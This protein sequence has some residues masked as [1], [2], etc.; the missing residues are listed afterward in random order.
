MQRAVFWTCNLRFII[1]TKYPVRLWNHIISNT[2][3]ELN[4]E[5]W[6]WSNISKCGIWFNYRSVKG[7]RT[8]SYL[9]LLVPAPTRPIANMALWATS[10]SLSCENLLSVSKMLSFGL[11]T[12]IRPSA[13]GTDLLITGSQYR[14]CKDT[15]PCK[16]WMTYY[17]R[18][19]FQLQSHIFIQVLTPGLIQKMIQF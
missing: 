16:I 2:T 17:S 5:L 4:G 1:K 12:D 15:T 3:W 9:A 18:C 14:N 6:T 7:Q 10:E 19:R 8:I 13:R 11:D